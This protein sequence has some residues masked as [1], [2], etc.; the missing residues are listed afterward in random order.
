LRSDILWVSTESP[1]ECDRL[2]SYHY[3]LTFGSIYPTGLYMVT[4]RVFYQT[5]VSNRRP[6]GS[7]NSWNFDAQ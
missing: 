1:S 2:F 7:L 5:A 6:F 3:L 4:L